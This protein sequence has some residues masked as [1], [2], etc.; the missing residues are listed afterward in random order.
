MSAAIRAVK[1][2]RHMFF[3]EYYSNQE[4]FFSV[5]VTLNP[6]PP[7]LNLNATQMPFCILGG[8]PHPFLP[9]LVVLRAPGPFRIGLGVLG[10]TAPNPAIAWVAVRELKLSY[11]NMCI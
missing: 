10:I 11:H 3:L 6:K 2:R 4:E 7:T 8:E 5:S 1:P 9:G